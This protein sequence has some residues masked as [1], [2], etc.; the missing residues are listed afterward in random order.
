M[1]RPSAKGVL[2]LFTS[3]FFPPIINFFVFAYSARI[4]APEDFGFIAL[5][6]SIIFIFSAFTPSGWRNAIIKF[7]LDDSLSISSVFWLNFIISLSLSLLIVLFA[8]ISYFDFQ[9]K[10]FNLA[11]TVLSL[12]LIFDSLFYTLNVVLLKRHLYSLL[13]VRTVASSIISAIVIVCLL[14]L[15]FGIWALIWSQVI[16]SFAN[17]I[18]V[19]IPTRDIIK[20]KFCF[21]TLK[22]MNSFA[23]YSTLTEGVTGILNNY[24]AIIIAGLIG[25]RDLGFVN[26]AKR[27]TQIVNGIFIG[28]VSEISFP[29]LAAKQENK[30]ELKKSFLFVVYLSVICL[31]PI[32]SFAIFNS[33]QIIEMLFTAKWLEATLPLQMSCVTFFFIILGIPQRNIVILKNE[34]K[35]WFHLQLKL[36]SIILP[37]S[38]LA[39]YYGLKPLLIMI[40]VGKS[41]YWFSSLF[42]ACSLLSLRKRDYL[43]SFYRPI[44]CNLLAVGATLFVN[45]LLPVFNIIFINVAL[46]AVFYFALYLLLLFFFE[47]QKIILTLQ[48]VLPHNKYI[49]LLPVI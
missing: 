36:S 6:L 34:A 32:F 11:L 5:A 47:R 29:I 14:L 3:K 25:K 10:I 45:T 37:A 26:V 24:D 28:T 15:D 4:L 8:W 23:I 39:A 20:F 46:S 44:I 49:K 19:Y 35:W 18:A 30:D 40:V 21:K 33:S 41:L 38:A 13:A 2:W 9:S 48:K 27:L 16:L 12:K 43:A 17:F 1:S 22:K 31:F 42:K 7:Q